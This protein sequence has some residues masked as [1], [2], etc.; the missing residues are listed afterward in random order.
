MGC[1]LRECLNPECRHA[2]GQNVHTP[3]PKCEG[4]MDFQFDEWMDHDEA[5]T[6]EQQIAEDFG[7]CV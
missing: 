3:C 4:K 2:D 5:P 7:K 1:I 6:K